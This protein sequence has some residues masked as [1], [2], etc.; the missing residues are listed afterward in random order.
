M[1]IDLELLTE[2]FVEEEREDIL[3]HIIKEEEEEAIAYIVQEETDYIVKEEEEEDLE[4]EKD[5]VITKANCQ[6]GNWVITL[7]YTVLSFMGRYTFCVIFSNIVSL[8]NPWHLYYIPVK[9]HLFIPETAKTYASQWGNIPKTIS[10][11]PGEVKK[12]K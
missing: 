2:V 9:N 10:K 6:G 3:E 8:V 7:S 11:S 5:E 1:W 12:C 4:L